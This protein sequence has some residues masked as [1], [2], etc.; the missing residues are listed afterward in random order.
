MIYSA[1]ARRHGRSR[2]ACAAGRTRGLEVGS[3]GQAVG[4]AARAAAASW[5]FFVPAAPSVGEMA[6]RTLVRSAEVNLFLET[7]VPP[8]LSVQR[9]LQDARRVRLVQSSRLHGTAL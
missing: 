7:L 3:C 6:Q 5:I 8:R 2:L 9:Q 1:S 4:S